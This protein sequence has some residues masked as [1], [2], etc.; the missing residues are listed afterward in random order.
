MSAS[1]GREEE[2]LRSVQLIS[3]GITAME[4][5]EVSP[6]GGLKRD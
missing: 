2:I 4:I 5:A 6:L 1:L 3:G